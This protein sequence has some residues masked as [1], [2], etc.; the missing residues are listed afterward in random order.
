MEVL[1]LQW[2]KTGFFPTSNCVNT[3][4]WMH[5]IMWTKR[6]EKRLNGN[7]TRMLCY[8][9]QILH[10]TFHKTAALWALTSHLKNHPSNIKKTCKTLLEKQRQTQLWCYGPL[11]IYMPICQTKNLHQICVDSGCSLEN[12]PWVMN[13]RDR[14]RE[15]VRKI[16]TVSMTRQ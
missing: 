6:M 13:D 2:N 1:S 3:M 5:C 15:R 8:F 10:A 16:H 11:L 9:E 12:L 7:Y 14:W 4:I